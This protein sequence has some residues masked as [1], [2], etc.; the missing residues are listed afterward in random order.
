MRAMISP[1]RLSIRTFLAWG[2]GLCLIACAGC[3]TVSPDGVNLLQSANADYNS[4]H[5][6]QAENQAA[7]F[8]DR[9]HDTPVVAEAYYLRGM[10]RVQQKQY[11]SAEADFQRALENSKRKDLTAKVHAIMGSVAMIQDK[12]GKAVEHYRQAIVGLEEHPPKDEIY[13][14]YAIALQRIGQWDE[15]RLCLARVVDG[16]PT[17]AYAPLA[18]RRLSWPGRF[19]SIQCGMYSQAAYA[20]QHV[21]R[22]RQSGMNARRSMTIVG[23]EPRYVVYVGRYSTY[24]DAC[25][26][27][28]RVRAVVKDAVVVP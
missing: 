8:I 25:I 21:G 2:A 28:A 7:L 20:D 11:A 18:K 5:W 6:P 10:A 14:R 9:Y 17:S 24:R 4:N 13:Y 16:Y 23:S 22:L 15:A 19:F 26:D 27:L 1:D 12:P 3:S